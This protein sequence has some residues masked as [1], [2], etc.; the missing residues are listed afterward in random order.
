M[1]AALRTVGVGVVCQLV[2]VQP[3]HVSWCHAQLLGA[4]TVDE[5]A[6]TLQIDTENSFPGGLQQL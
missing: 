5:G 2:H 3:K 6:A 1:R 4:C